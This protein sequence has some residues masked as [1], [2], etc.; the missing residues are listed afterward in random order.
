M[1][2]TSDDR[3]ICKV[4]HDEV[5]PAFVMV[6][7]QALF[8]GVNV[9]YKIA[10]A[11]G[12]NAAVL[13]FY[14]FLFAAGFIAPIAFI[15][16]RI[17]IG[18]N[19]SVKIV[20]YSSA[21]FSAAI[22]N[23]DPAITFI[24]AVILRLERLGWQ[25]PAGKAKVLGTIVGICGAIV[26][27][28]YKGPEINLW[29]TNIN[30]LHSSPHLKLGTRPLLGA[31]LGL[32]CC[33]CYSL[34]LIIQGKAADKYPCPYSFTALTLAMGSIQSFVYALCVERNWEEWKLAWNVKLLAIT[35]LG[36]LGG[37]VLFAM[38]TWCVGVKG[39]VYVSAFTPLWLILMAIVG[40]LCLEEKLHLGYI[41][42]GVLI[43]MGLY[44]VLWG[45]QE[46]IKR[47]KRGGDDE[48][49]QS[50]V[51]EEGELKNCKSP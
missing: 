47:E 28:S 20:I 42:G 32:A 14:R 43:M 15:A 30:V 7:V 12:M 50:V 49:Q 2:A 25:R 48:A 34:L 35:Y 3:S 4:L 46:E 1:A 5:K 36:T 6:V 13:T 33:V 29:N 9:A 38:S 18:M 11:A 16:E 22:A 51:E 27:T 19:L 44:V 24:I 21:T 10:Y 23:L 40:S 26:F 39:P 17:A 41:F 8:A 37:G 45:K 31:F